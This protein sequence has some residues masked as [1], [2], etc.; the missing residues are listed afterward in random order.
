MDIG[1]AGMVWRGEKDGSWT[2]EAFILVL[3][4]V[5]DCTCNTS[6]AALSLVLSLS[7]TSLQFLRVCTCPSCYLYNQRIAGALGEKKHWHCSNS[8]QSVIVILNVTDVIESQRPL[9]ISCFFSLLCSPGSSHAYSICL[10][11]LNNIPV[12]TWESTSSDQAR[13][14]HTHTQSQHDEGPGNFHSLSVLRPDKEKHFL[15]VD[16]FQRPN[17]LLHAT[18]KTSSISLIW[19]YLSLTV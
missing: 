3:R 6:L 2:T 17:L 7:S 11:A 19:N 13:P 18:A 4:T 10:R 8:T 14:T 12:K 16:T 1:A 9:L 5:C 15:F